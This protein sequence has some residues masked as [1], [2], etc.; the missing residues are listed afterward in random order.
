MTAPLAGIELNR[1]AIQSALAALREGRSTGNATLDQVV[2]ALGRRRAR[3]WTHFRIAWPDVTEAEIDL[4]A[5]MVVDVL[6]SVP[7][8]VIKLVIADA[9]TC[10]AAGGAS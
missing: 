4:A 8:L 7:V 1:A 2:I 5:D 10:A 6:A 3:A 9:A